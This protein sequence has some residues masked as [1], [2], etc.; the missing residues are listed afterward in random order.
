MNAVEAPIREEHTREEEQQPSEF[1][2]DAVSKPT[3]YKYQYTCSTRRNLGIQRD[4]IIKGMVSKVYMKCILKLTQG[5]K[6]M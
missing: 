2:M 1:F 3:D 6:Q 5:P 4:W